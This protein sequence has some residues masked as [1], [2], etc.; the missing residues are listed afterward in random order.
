MKKLLLVTLLFSKI[1]SAQT[2]TYIPYPENYVENSFEWYQASG[3]PD[4][5]YKY[6]SEIYGDTIIGAFT[7]KKY[8]TGPTGSAVLTAAI[9][10]DIPNKKVYQYNFTS[11]TETILFDFD[12]SIGDTVQVNADWGGDTV[13]VDDIDSVLLLDGL[14]HNRY[15]L[16]NDNPN[17]CICATRTPSSLVEGLGYFDWN[18]YSI[19]PESEFSFSTFGRACAFA[20]GQPLINN[21]TSSGFPGYSGN[22]NSLWTSIDETL[23]EALIELFPNPTT[24][25]FQIKG[26]EQKHLTVEVHDLLGSK[27]KMLKTDNELL[28]DLSD[29]PNGIYF[30]HLSDSNGNAVTKKIVKQ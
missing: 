13:W 18:D 14:Y 26:A 23:N 28:I 16:L 11:S 21:L 22:C 6:H 29:Q 12:L 19:M 7:Y 2:G 4:V 9:R 25:K 5:F 24:G 1:A 8:Y 30:V 3:V 15:K 20:D 17:P 10:N 27:I